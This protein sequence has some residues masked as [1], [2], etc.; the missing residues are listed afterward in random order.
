MI[1]IETFLMT[2]NPFEKEGDAFIDFEKNFTRVKDYDSNKKFEYPYLDGALVITIE[3]KEVLTFK[4]W[5]M[6]ILVWMDLIKG[7]CANSL[8]E[9]SQ[10][11]FPDQSTEVLFKPLNNE[12]ISVFLN[13]AL[14]VNTSR[15]ELI[16]SIVEEGKTFFNKLILLDPENRS[17]YQE[18]LKSL[19]SIEE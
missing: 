18:E 6:V 14:I 3:G 2:N 7:I 5:D 12:E 13:N 11:G 19:D 16:K 9:Q 4:H 17:I 1:Y 8:R 15:K 10:F